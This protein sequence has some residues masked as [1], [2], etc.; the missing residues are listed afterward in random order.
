M[1]V[2]SGGLLLLWLVLVQLSEAADSVWVHLDT[3]DS[4]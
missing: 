4:V 2:A 3:T 1:A